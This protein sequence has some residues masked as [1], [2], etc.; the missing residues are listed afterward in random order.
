VDAYL[1]FCVPDNHPQDLDRPGWE[2]K[3]R[4]RILAPKSIRVEVQDPKLAMLSPDHA[5]IVYRQ[6]Y[7]TEDSK[8]TSRKR[9]GLTLVD[10]YWKILL[11][12]EA[13]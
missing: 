12:K 13:R 2:A 3:R 8:L 10:G 6:I 11:E 5:E 7:Q 4:Q 1:A 9:I